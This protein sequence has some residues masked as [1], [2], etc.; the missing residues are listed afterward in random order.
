MDLRSYYK[1]IRDAEATLPEG[2]IVMASLVTSEGGKEGVRTE[3][4][5]A[6]AAKLIVEGRSR[7]A[8]P[9]EANEFHEAN[10]EARAK[11]EQEEA[12]RRVQVMLLPSQDLRKTK[13]RS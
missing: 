2:H 6:T 7:V 4:S 1:K 13:E 3:A 5:R 8:T 12:A 11:H 10:R 9:E